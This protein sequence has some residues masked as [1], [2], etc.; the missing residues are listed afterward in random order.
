MI[1][2]RITAIDLRDAIVE[3]RAM[4]SA[5]E[6]TVSEGENQ[7]ILARPAGEPLLRPPPSRE[8][9]KTGECRPQ[10]E[11]RLGCAIGMDMEGTE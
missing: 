6:P 3:F 8:I 10:P 4:R 2:R 1:N 5:D 7:W 9:A 11:G